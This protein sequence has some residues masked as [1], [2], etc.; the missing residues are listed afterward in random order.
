MCNKIVLVTF[1]ELGIDAHFKE[2]L[3]HDSVCV[4]PGIPFFHRKAE[5]LCIKCNVCGVFNFGEYSLF[6]KQNTYAYIF[7]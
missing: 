3:P 7:D 5:V 1:S 6:I 4:L 2:S